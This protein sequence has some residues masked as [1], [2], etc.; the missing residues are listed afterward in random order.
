MTDSIGRFRFERSVR[1][2][3]FGEFMLDMFGYLRPRSQVFKH[4]MCR[5]CRFGRTNRPDMDMVCFLYLLVFGQKAF[6]LFAVDTFGDTIYGK[7]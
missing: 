2:T 4:D 6:Y 7:P 3:M 1:D 5:E